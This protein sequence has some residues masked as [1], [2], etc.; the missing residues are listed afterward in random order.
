MSDECERLLY[1]NGIIKGGLKGSSCRVQGGYEGSRKCSSR[2]S[3][4]CSSKCRSRGTSGGA[5]WGGESVVIEP[6]DDENESHDEGHILPLKRRLRQKITKF[7]EA[8]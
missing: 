3:S 2:S 7:I 6:D 8:L 5:R 1:Y 4:K